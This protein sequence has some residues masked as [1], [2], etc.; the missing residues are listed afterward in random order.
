MSQTIIEVY[1]AEQLCASCVNLP[2]STETYDWIQAAI[3]RTFE[4]EDIAFS[5]VDIHKPLKEAERSFAQ[6][7]LN[8]EYYYP[9]VLVNGKVVGEGNPRLKSIY[10]ALEDAG[11]ERIR[12]DR[13]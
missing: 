11:I 9:V 12:D 4:T 1:G 8:D 10:K 6:R 5:Y 7:I 13:R 3:G 2:S